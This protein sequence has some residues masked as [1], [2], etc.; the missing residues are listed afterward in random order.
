M[1]QAQGLAG[2]WRHRLCRPAALPWLVLAGGL[3][4]T[5]LFC[6]SERQFRQLEHERIETTLAADIT[7]VITA[8]LVTTTAM[9]DAAVGLFDA[10][11][12]VTLREFKAFF[13]SLSLHGDN[14]KGIQ[15]V[16]FS[17]RVP[18]DGIAAFEQQIR[19]EGQPDFRIRPA[20]RRAV[21]SAI[22]YLQP[23][24]WR[25][26]RAIGFD[27]YSEATRRAAMQEAADT[28]EPSLSGPVRLVQETNRR[29][30]TGTLLYLPIYSE[31]SKPFQSTQERMRRLRGWAYAPMRMG[32]LINSALASLNNPDKAGTGVLIYDGTKPSPEQLLYDNLNLAGSD[33]LTHPTWVPVSIANRTWLIGIQLDHRNVNPSGWSLNL[34]LTALLGVS[35]SSLAAVVTRNLVSNHTALELALRQEQAAAQERALATTVFDSSPVAIVVTDANGFILRVNQAFTQLSGYS[36]LEARGRKANLLRSGRHDDAFYAELW[37]S[38]IQRGHWSGEIWNRHRNGQIRRH[39]LNI[40]AVL[41]DR[42]QIVSFV[43]LLQDVTERYDQQ[44]EMR[45]L[46]THD[47]LTGLANRN[48]LMEQLISSLAL[49]RRQDTRVALLFIDLNR[50]KPVNDRYGHS[51]GDALLQAVAERL[52]SVVRE[53]DTLCRQGGDE[54]V[55]LLPNAPDLEQLRTMAT[56][57]QMELTRPYENLPADL[58][59][60]ASFGIARWPD[61]AE[62]ADG[63]LEAADNAMYA[64][65]QQEG[66]HIAMAAPPSRTPSSP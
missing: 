50:F 49:A 17:A 65:K 44:E 27:M 12:K 55:L 66:D 40:T 42:N 37:E 54:F 33:R 18:S 25:N 32:D 51:V 15:G 48:L 13:R 61:H 19:S 7:E 8:R 30:Q 53:S 1:T 36:A 21:T 59:V 4:T 2:Q 63:L 26:Q 34:M 56:K 5:G 38:I 6:N 28:G 23:S 31:P 16:G 22:V 45:H 35:I 41:D 10:S 14:L 46:A 47:Q 39:E 58:S 64:A 62:D 52:R 3:L 9:L 60:S 24:D 57:L 29:P 20:G 11:E 43:G